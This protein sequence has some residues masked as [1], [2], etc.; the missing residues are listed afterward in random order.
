MRSLA[1]ALLLVAGSASVARAD[2][3]DVG[4]ADDWCATINAAAPGDEVALAGGTYDRPCSIRASGS[5]V[6]PIV[7]RSAS[8][9]PGMRAVLAYT[10]TTSNVLDLRSVA[11]VVIRALDFS[12]TQDDVDAIKLHSSSDVVIER[13]TFR[14]VGGVSISA[15]DGDSA[16]ISVRDN[17]LRALRATGMYFGCH[18]GIACHATDVV[19]E[20][21]VVS[22]VTPRAPAV[23]YGVEV[24]LDSYATIRDN[25]VYDT[26]GPGLMVYGSNRGDP[27]SVLEG[28]YVEGTRGD[29][30]LLVGGG[31]AIVRN[32]VAVRCAVAAI[33]AQDY[34]GRDL[35]A[36]VWLVHN[37]LVD[38][39]ADAIAIERWRDGR[40]NVIAFN[41]VLVGATGDVLAPAVPAGTVIGN[42]ACAD[43]ATC[44]VAA[45]AAPYDL[46]PAADGPLVD[47]A[48]AGAQ[49]WRP[50]D[51]FMGSARGELADV[52][53]IERTMTA[54]ALRLGAG[55][56]R[57]ERATGPVDS[58]GGVRPGVDGGRV[59]V[60]DAGRG[61]DA[62]PVD[63]T[64]PSSADAGGAGSTADEGCGCGAVGDAGRSAP[65]GLGL[66]VVALAAV[67][68]RRRW[69]T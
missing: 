14:D 4:P 63:A 54:E 61:V 27:P 18:D 15:N 59:P 69:R 37:T 45:A 36:G 51:D 21:N 12:S 66:L 39:P 62:A 41:A 34:A 1:L 48:G 3:H 58:D 56:P 65:R 57:P 7:V 53:A 13:C 67:A 60:I 24:K 42:V 17:V 5:A 25:T 6:A 55:L 10:G 32:N 19:I 16:R 2:V 29:A 33:R 50:A 46:T 64:F 31:P 43:T 49:P 26:A 38:N 8:E 35:Q 68:A 20:R 9:A 30:C 52:G 22:G 40:D 23:G 11:H 44:F 28:N 47:A